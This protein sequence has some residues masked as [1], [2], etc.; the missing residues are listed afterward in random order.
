MRKAELLRQIL[1][2][3]EGADIGM[4]LGEH[5]LNITNVS[6][7]TGGGGE[8]AGVHCDLGD[9]RDVMAAWKLT[10]SQINRLVPEPEPERDVM[11][12]IADAVADSLADFGYVRLVDEHVRELAVVLHAY[13]TSTGLPVS[14]ESA[15]AFFKL[16]RES[17]PDEII[18]S[19]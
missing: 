19:E 12:R 5:S 9:L 1:A 14:L 6:A 15:E 8:S 4:R 16:V 3:P 17:R 13:V 11:V 18:S 7:A 2:L 10:P